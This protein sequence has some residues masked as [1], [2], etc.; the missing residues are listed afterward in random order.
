MK[1]PHCEHEITDKEEKINRIMAGFN[2]HK[3]R[4]AM[5]ALG[6]TWRDEGVPTIEKLRETARRLLVD[7]S[8]NEFGNIMT[9][10]FKAEYHK[11]GEFSLEFILAETNSYEY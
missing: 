1:C 10:G 4:K 11:D 7:A 3:V 6:W 9:G 5:V 2:F 8:E